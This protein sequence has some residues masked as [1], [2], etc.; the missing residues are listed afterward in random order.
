[1]DRKNKKNIGIKYLLGFFISVVIFYSF[2]VRGFFGIFSTFFTEYSKEFSY[3]KFSTIF[4]GQKMQDVHSVLGRPFLDSSDQLSCDWY[5]RPRHF[6]GRLGVT[7]Y[8]GWISVKVC[9]DKD[10]SVNGTAQNTFF[11]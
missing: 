7:D 1:M 9:Y 11:N 6:W 10:G 5:S 8:T 4:V 3:K 2:F